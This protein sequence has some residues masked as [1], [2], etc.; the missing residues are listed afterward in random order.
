MG[1]RSTARRRSGRE[2]SACGSSTRTFDSRI[3]R[4]QKV[5]F[6]PHP[7]TRARGGRWCD[8]GIATVERYA[9][10]H[11]AA[12]ISWP[13]LLPL[14][15]H[16]FLKCI[17]H[18]PAWGATPLPA[19]VSLSGSSFAREATWFGRSL[20]HKYKVGLERGESRRQRAPCKSCSPY[21]R[22]CSRIRPIVTEPK[23]WRPL[24]NHGMEEHGGDGDGRRRGAR[25]QFS[26]LPR[27]R[28]PRAVR[29]LIRA[30]AVSY[31]RHGE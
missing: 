11:S 6:P 31:P 3:S 8:H 9:S 18:L 10:V 15:L 25:V 24:T 5:H 17:Y 14:R 19:Y 30:T 27:A 7:C 23:I 22:F 1:P 12:E 21:H 4:N 26:P 13:P 29:F 20:Q 2:E 16:P 28:P